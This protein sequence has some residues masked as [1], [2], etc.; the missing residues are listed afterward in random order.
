MLSPSREAVVSTLAAAGGA[1][2]AVAVTLVS[3][4]K[5]LELEERRRTREERREWQTRLLDEADEWA[6]EVVEAFED[7]SNQKTTLRYYDG[8]L[9]YAELE[10]EDQE[11]VEEARRKVERQGLL[12]QARFYS[13]YREFERRA[14][15]RAEWIEDQAAANALEAMLEQ[16]GE[17]HRV[18]ED[19]L[20]AAQPDDYLPSLRDQA[21]IIRRRYAEAVPEQYRPAGG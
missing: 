15:A 16:L 9:H 1:A 19:G 6:H 20:D 21:E 10:Q 3:V 8:F 2:A 11:G 7:M 5:A 17:W 12:R 18:A 14:E 13:R 4:V